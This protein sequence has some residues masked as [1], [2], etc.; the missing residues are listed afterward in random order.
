MKFRIQ[1]AVRIAG[2]TL[3]LCAVAGS[4]MALDLGGMFEKV[5][6][7]FAAINEKGEQD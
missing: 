3:G 2:L 1:L 7:D 4:A 6:G 5:K